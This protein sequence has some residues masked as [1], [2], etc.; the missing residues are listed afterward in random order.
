MNDGEMKND[1]TIDWIYWIWR[2]G[3][4]HVKRAAGRK[5]DHL[6]FRL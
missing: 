5:E 1:S 3:F 6:Y 4:C 2:S